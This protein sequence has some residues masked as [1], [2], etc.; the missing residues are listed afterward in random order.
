ME[1]VK[2]RGDNKKLLLW[3]YI[4]FFVLVITS[5][6]INILNTKNVMNMYIIFAVTSGAI[7]LYSLFYIIFVKK[8]KKP[9]KLEDNN[10]AFYVSLNKNNTK[11]KVSS[12][13]IDSFMLLALVITSIYYIYKMKFIEVYDFYTI[14]ASGFIAVLNLSL[15][16]KDIVKLKSM[17]RIDANTSS[18]QFSIIDKK[19]LFAL[20]LLLIATANIGIL[21]FTKPHFVVYYNDLLTFEILSTILLT[22]SL[23]SILITKLYYYSYS[24]KQIEQ[25]EFNTRFLEEIGEGRYAKVYKAYVPSLDTVYAVKKLES[26]DVTDI[27]RFKAEFNIMRMLDHNNLLRVYSF[28]EIKYEY[29]MDYCQYNLDSYLENHKLSPD[30]KKKLTLQLLDS[31]DYLH[32]HGIMHRDVSPSNIMIK[33]NED[34]HEPTL[35]VLDFGISKNTNEIK[36]T[37]TLTRIRGT[38]FD[39]TLKDFSRYNEQNDIY[40]LGVI[41]NYINYQDDSIIQDDSDVSK[42]VNKCMDL[43]LCNRYHHVNEIINDYKEATL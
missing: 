36:K 28:D 31:F 21:A 23:T 17:D 29:V 15:I 3:A 42:I 20:N 8:N 1:K 2:Y 22:L 24:I 12:L 34:S 6:I 35:K 13:V 32:K 5:L 9:L 19:L 38:L 14:I 16:I 10:L 30:Y 4:A 37:R 7:L 43:N 27:E 33:E 41:I 40:G 18:H 11:L 26:K 39:P 25:T